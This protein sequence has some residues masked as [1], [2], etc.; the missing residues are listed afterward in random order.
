M[1]GGKRRPTPPSG[2]GQSSG[3]NVT[4]HADSTSLGAKDLSRWRYHDAP[5]RWRDRDPVACR[6]LRMGTIFG[7]GRGSLGRP[8]RARHGKGEPLATERRRHRR[9]DRF[10]TA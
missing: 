5:P 9:T 7:G 3:R 8:C 2:T 10:G 4:N 6:L 1:A